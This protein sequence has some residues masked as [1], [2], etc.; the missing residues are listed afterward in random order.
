[1]HPFSV[2]EFEVN[3]A[4][5]KEILEKE[6]MALFAGKEIA[7][8]RFDER[9][10]PLALTHPSTIGLIELDYVPC[11]ICDAKLSV[12]FVRDEGGWPASVTTACT[13]GLYMNRDIG[14]LLLPQDWLSSTL[15]PSL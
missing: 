8:V 3:M 11:P 6:R 1:M 12:S 13:C 14:Q 9:G 2:L 10:L 15:E 5:A 4:R 7:G